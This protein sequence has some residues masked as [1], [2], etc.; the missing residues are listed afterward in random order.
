MLREGIK[1]L[2]NNFNTESAEALE[3]HA[4]QWGTWITANRKMLS[5]VNMNINHLDQEIKRRKRQTHEEHLQGKQSWKPVQEQN[6]GPTKLDFTIVNTKMLE[7]LTSV[8]E[9]LESV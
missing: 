4:A 3:K 7:R 9:R 8:L 6:T 1:L 5:E 2:E